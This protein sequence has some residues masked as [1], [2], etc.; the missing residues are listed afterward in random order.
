MDSSRFSDKMTQDLCGQPLIKFVIGQ[1][2]RIKNLSVLVVATTNR[3]I[4]DVIAEIAEQSC[5]NV[6]RGKVDDVASRFLECARK[7]NG[8]YLARLNGDS[9]CIDIDLVESGISLCPYGYDII[10][11]VLSRTFPYG[12]S[13]EI[14]KAKG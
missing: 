4:D 7:Y 3:P 10:T 2:K 8:D 11:N 6:Y 12:I 13:V 9:P 5:V 14:V 1:A